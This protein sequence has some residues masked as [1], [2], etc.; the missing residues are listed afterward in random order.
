MKY[1]LAFYLKPE[2]TLQLFILRF[3]IFT[4]INDSVITLDYVYLSIFKTT[5]LK[6]IRQLSMTVSG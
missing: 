5:I 6:L 4:A 1:G 3:I 2:L